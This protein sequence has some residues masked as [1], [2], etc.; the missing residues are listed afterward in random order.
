MRSNLEVL[1]HEYENDI[2][3][4]SYSLIGKL[5]QSP[6][7]NDIKAELIELF[8]AKFL[9]FLRNPYS[10]QKMLSTVGVVANY[11]P[12]DPDLRKAYELVREGSKPHRETVCSRFELTPDLYDRWLTS[13]FMLLTPAPPRHIPAFQQL[14]KVVFESSHVM[15]QVHQYSANDSGGGANLCLL[16]DRGFNMPGDVTW[17]FMFDFN[18]T[19]RALAKFIFCDPAKYFEN[20]APVYAASLRGQV[21]VTP[22]LDDVDALVRYNQLTVFQCKRTVF[23]AHASPRLQK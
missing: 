5:S 6:P 22:F 20:L 16:S 3:R 10:V 1:F 13:L 18:V 15:V 21:K 8:A 14:L 12:H 7:D 17:G 4:I 9:N 19:S 11:V 23:A 2:S